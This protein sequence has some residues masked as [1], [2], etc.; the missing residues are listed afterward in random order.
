MGP[1]TVMTYLGIV[2]DSVK[3]EARITDERLTKNP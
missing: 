1:D 2:L 3:M